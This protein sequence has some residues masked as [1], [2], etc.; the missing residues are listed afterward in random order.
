MLPGPG[1]AW[2]IAKSSWYCFHHQ[3]NS[4]YQ[5]LFFSLPF[6]RLSIDVFQQI[7]CGTFSLQ[8]TCFQNN[9]P[10]AYPTIW[11]WAAGPP[12][13]VKPKCQLSLS[14]SCNLVYIIE[15]RDLLWAII[16][17]KILTQ[18]NAILEQARSWSF[19]YANFFVYSIF[20]FDVKPPSQNITF[21]VCRQTFF[22]LL[23]THFCTIDLN[24]LCGQ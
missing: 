16:I 17:T 7:N 8:Q 18:Y 5:M 20:A 10:L 4:I 2:H 23:H 15:S 11:K 9:Y 19:I 1:S 22:L 24:C 21:S 6:A 14:I 3:H 13:L 12:K